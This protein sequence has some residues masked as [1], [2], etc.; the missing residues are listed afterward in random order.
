MTEKTERKFLVSKAVPDT[1]FTG[2]KVDGKQMNFAKN[3]DSFYLSDPAV[4][5]DLEQSLGHAKGGAKKLLVTEIPNWKSKDEM[6]GHYFKFSVRKRVQ[7]K[8]A[9]PSEYVWVSDG[10][11]KQVRVHK[12]MV[13]G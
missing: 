8:S 6:S 2:V 1:D 7:L 5:H 9:T 11:G 4:A 12:D 10:K 3:G 13:N